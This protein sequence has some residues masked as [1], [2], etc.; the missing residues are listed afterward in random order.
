S[1]SVPM[2]LVVMS[3]TGR[4]HVFSPHRSIVGWCFSK[5]SRAIVFS[6]TALHGP[7]DESFELHRVEDGKLLKEFDLPWKDLDRQI[8]GLPLEVRIPVWA[9]CAATYPGQKA[10]A[11]Q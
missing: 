11:G 10:G 3:P 5:D 4:L 6:I 2:E 8:N 1:Y 9:V 7:T